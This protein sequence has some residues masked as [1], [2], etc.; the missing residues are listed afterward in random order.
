MASFKICIHFIIEHLALC[1]V[2]LLLHT[3]FDLLSSPGH[4]VSLVYSEA[5]T[6]C[7]RE[8]LFIVESLMAVYL[9]ALALFDIKLSTGN[10]FTLIETDH[11]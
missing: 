1:V 6:E 3:V 11:D 7:K 10:Y 5:L 8:A 2:K 9:S 4:I